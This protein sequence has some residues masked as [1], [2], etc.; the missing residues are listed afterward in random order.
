LVGCAKEFITYL[1]CNG[2]FNVWVADFVKLDTGEQIINQGQ[3]QWFIFINL[4]SHESERKN[5]YRKP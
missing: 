3:K 4:Q 5:S 2:S 1:V